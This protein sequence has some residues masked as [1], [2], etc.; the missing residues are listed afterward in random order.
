MATSGFASSALPRGC[1][2]A[3]IHRVDDSTPLVICVLAQSGDH[4][5]E[6]PF[7]LLRDLPGARIY[8]GAVC[9][10]F[11]NIQ[12]WVEVQVQTVDVKQLESSGRDEMLSNVFFDSRWHRDGTVLRK[13]LPQAVIATR[14]EA[15]NPG[16]IL[17]MRSSEN[18]PFAPVEAV[19][20]RVC[21]EDELLK[22]HDLPG[23]ATSLFRYLFQP[24]SKDAK[25]FIATASDAP[26]NA[27]VQGLD[28]FKSKPGVQAIFNPGGGFVRIVRY[29]PLELESYLQIL[30]GRAWNEAN[31]ESPFFLPHSVYAALREWSAHQRGLPFLLRGQTGGGERL[32]E[33][34]LLKLQLLLDLFKRVRNFVKIHQVPLLNLS[35]A[36]FRI[37]VSQTGDLF[38]A[39]W[40]A[41]SQLARTGQAYPLQIES[42]EHKYFVRLGKSEPT[43]F[44]P[45]S[46]GTHSSGIASAQIRD[47]QMSAD[48]V[49]LEGTLVAEDF[50]AADPHDLLWF[51]LP[52]GEDRL[53][54]YGHLH[55]SEGGPQREARFRTLP[56]MLSEAVVARLKASAGVRFSKAPYEIRPLLSSPCDLFS[57]GV[58]GVRI[59][60]ANKLKNLPILLDEV[61]S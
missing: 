61:L 13:Q 8:L 7:V 5:T 12:E 45:G 44:F 36:S 59:L 51:K 2:L 47:V 30:E 29:S 39:L 33:I 31:S 6:N 23:Y 1:V 41:E 60:L 27:V 28:Q 3:P 18:E 22:S 15:E 56:T 42:T 38:P 17:I 55:K 11:G 10:A 4:A 35:P 24:G 37:H 52:S 43:P 54:F 48:R 21:K 34:F 53:E 19:P 49:V 50:L 58:I 25:T 46:L 26:V 57:L 20:W 32:N 16:P 40:S 14:M 9:D